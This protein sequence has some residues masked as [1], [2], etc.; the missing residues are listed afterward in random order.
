MD[1]IAV[2]VQ[3]VSK[4]YPLYRRPADRLKEMLT[5]WRRSYHTDFWA[6]RDIS[7]DV[8]KGQTLGII[9]QNG[10]GKSTLLQIIAG[11]LQPT[12]GTVTVN[13]RVT[14]LLELGTGFN[15]EFTG[16]ENVYMSGAILGISKQ[17]M[18]ER[19]D[20][21]AAFAQIGQFI[22]Q[23]VKTYSSGMYVRLAFAIA[24]SL[25][26][27]LLIVDEALAVGDTMF[28]RRCYRR[29]EELQQEGKTILFVSHDTAVV[30]AVCDQALLL[31][32]GR[33]IASGH[34]KMVANVCEELTLKREKEY[35][36]GLVA[37]RK[38]ESRRTDTARM[39]VPQVQ[40]GEIEEYRFGSREA[41]IVDF[42]L[43]NNEGQPTTVLETGE[44]CRVAVTARFHKD[45]QEPIVGMVMHTATGI[46]VCG[47]NTWYANR[48]PG[49]QQAGDLLT[50]E[51]KQKL[52]LNP[53]NYTLSVGVSEL[54]PTHIV[55]LDRRMDAL[56]FRMVGKRRF[57]G[58]VEINPVIT[59]K[60]QRELEE[61]PEG[62]GAD[63]PGTVVVP[64]VSKR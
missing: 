35:V 29:L 15:P 62:A 50:V 22:D 5:R 54:F 42:A 31:D 60:K 14:A 39:A 23:P 26:P 45:V 27:D 44:E 19:F 57:S 28:Q 55:D 47:S 33:V 25:D 18:H 59:F 61:P 63:D 6:L 30:R 1:E 46:D 20:D 32:V 40:S 52:N 58:L 16:R 51:F 64:S 53:G 8:P 10:A 13:G 24:A 48:N 17:E 41:E 7:F 36:E 21:I 4:V 12:T 38:G 43:I 56:A 11:V 34:P 2:S 49:P 3:N 37:G 9:G